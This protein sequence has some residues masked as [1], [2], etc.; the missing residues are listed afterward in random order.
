MIRKQLSGFLVALW[1]VA[2]S[3]AV[4]PA[5]SQTTATET[6]I[7]QLAGERSKEWTLGDITSWLSADAPCTTGERYRFYRDETVLQETCIEGKIIATQTMWRVRE[8]GPLDMIVEIGDTA[9]IL[10]FYDAVDGV[11]HMVL[12]S[13]TEGKAE[14][15]VDRD[16]SFSED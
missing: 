7:A 5:A 3:P 6:A 16:F 14:S 9:Y 10:Q 2:I 1:T 8:D 4:L 13:R 12:R 15:I 11:K